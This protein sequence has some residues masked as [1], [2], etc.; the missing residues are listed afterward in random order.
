MDQYAMRWN[1][2]RE[3]RQIRLTFRLNPR[4]VAKTECI[5]YVLA[6]L[7]SPHKAHR[8]VRVSTPAEISLYIFLS[9]LR[10]P[11]VCAPRG[12]MMMD[13]DTYYGTMYTHVHSHLE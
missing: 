9:P 3:N 4:C 13:T 10:L 6:L 8:C 7:P 11:F 12:R 2:A 5:S 1:V